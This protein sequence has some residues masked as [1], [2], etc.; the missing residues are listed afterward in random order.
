MWAEFL[1][2]GSLLH[3]PS[4]KVCPYSK[5]T[6]LSEEEICPFELGS[7]VCNA[8]GQNPNLQMNSHCFLFLVFFLVYFTKYKSFGCVYLLCIHVV[9]LLH[10][11]FCYRSIFSV[12]AL[13]C[14]FSKHYTFAKP[15]RFCCVWFCYR[16]IISIV[17]AL[18]YHF[19]VFVLPWY[20][21]VYMYL[22]TFPW[23]SLLWYL[24]WVSNFDFCI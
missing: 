1:T 2:F 3:L 4:I 18:P 22:V 9:F 21:Y 19:S 15:C 13:P 11:A 7:D 6:S 12:L 10:L 24:L 16:G 14:D 8:R 20:F 23:H 17:L 5:V